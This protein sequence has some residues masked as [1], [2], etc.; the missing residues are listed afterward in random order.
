MNRP[1][2]NTV[3]LKRGIAIEGFQVERAIALELFTL[4]TRKKSRQFVAD[5]E[6][7]T[8]VLVE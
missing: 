2:P 6:Q 5:L 4:Q 1:A 3:I 8:R 7:T